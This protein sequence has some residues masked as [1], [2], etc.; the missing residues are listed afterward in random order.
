MAFV[1]FHQDT[2]HIADHIPDKNHIDDI[3]FQE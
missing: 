3:S 1:G 2:L